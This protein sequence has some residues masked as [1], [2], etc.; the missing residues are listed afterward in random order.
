MY[1][2]TNKE[3]NK[4]NKACSALT[5]TTFPSFLATGNPVAVQ[6]GETPSREADQSLGSADSWLLQSTNIKKDA[7]HTVGHF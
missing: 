2:K 1:V 5:Y 4:E 7:W 6:F 3:T